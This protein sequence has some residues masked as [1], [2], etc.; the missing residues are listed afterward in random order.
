MRTH[1]SE[2]GVAGQRNMRAYTTTLHNKTCIILITIIIIINRL[3]GFIQMRNPI[4]V[5]LTL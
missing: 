2:F 5:K 4:A 1:A 3:I